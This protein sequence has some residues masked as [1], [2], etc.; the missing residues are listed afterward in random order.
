METRRWINQSQPQTLLIAVYLLYLT[1][2][3]A[4]L[5]GID[6]GTAYFLVRLAH[7]GSLGNLL[8]L[9]LVAAY[10][11]AGYGIANERK[12]GY[13]LGVGAAAVPLIGDLAY[14]I[15]YQR[16]PFSLDLI[17]LLFQVA[18]FVLLVHPQSRSYERIWFK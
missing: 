7:L 11:G 5:F 9:V 1:G 3:F 15:Q 17:N 4:L 16:S 13:Y 2:A 12:W 14:C 8:R 18:L 10:A 6:L